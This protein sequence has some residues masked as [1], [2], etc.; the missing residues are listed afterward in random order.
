VEHPRCSDGRLHGVS[1]ILVR[2]RSASP[3]FSTALLA[4][5]AVLS[6]CSSNWVR[7]EE[8]DVAY[9]V[10]SGETLYQIAFNRQLDYRDIAWWNGIGRDYLVYPGQILRLDPPLPGELRAPPRVPSHTAS[11]GGGRPPVVK[12][13]RSIQKP[14]PAQP[15]APAAGP[16]RWAWP[17]KGPI[18][19]RFNAAQGRKGIDIGGSTGTA[20][21]AAAAGKVVYAGGALK[22]YGQLLIIKHGE[23]YLTAYGHNAKLLVA[24]GQQVEAGARIASM[25]LGPQNRPLLHFEIRRMG[26]PVDPGSLLP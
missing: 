8:R 5:V 1:R 19:A 17:V 9:T 13:P 18:L 16:R 26:K 2:G 24:E 25:G 12:R 14:A 4:L 22:G 21:R 11:S 6:A 15:S 20:I 3:F 7:W 10:Q 23:E